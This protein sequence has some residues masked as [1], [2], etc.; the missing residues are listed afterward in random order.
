MYAYKRACLTDWHG[1]I[2]GNNF[3]GVIRDDS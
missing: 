1:L 3:T 2:N